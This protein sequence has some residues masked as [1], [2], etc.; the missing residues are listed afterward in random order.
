[1]LFVCAF[2]IDIDY[3][4]I[5]LLKRK[6][7]FFLIFY[8]SIIRFICADFGM[9]QLGGIAYSDQGFDRMSG[10]QKL[11]SDSLRSIFTKQIEVLYIK[12]S[13]FDIRY[14]IKTK[15]DESKR[16]WT[17]TVLFYNQKIWYNSVQPGWGLPY[18]ISGSS[19]I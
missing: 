4:D 11:N 14:C 15:A 8:S 7:N 12:R 16:F 9:Y 5:F 1:M 2:L 17:E 13:V 19:I 10:R 18:W 3:K 6:T